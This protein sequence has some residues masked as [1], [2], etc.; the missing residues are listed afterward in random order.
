[1]NELDTASPKVQWFGVLLLPLVTAAVVFSAITQI[2]SLE[3]VFLHIP[4][5]ARV[6]CITSLFLIPSY[7]WLLLNKELSHRLPLF[8]ILL[9]LYIPVLWVFALRFICALFNDCHLI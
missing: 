5:P 7:V 9:V 3:R 8:S 1:M 6:A 2:D 4:L